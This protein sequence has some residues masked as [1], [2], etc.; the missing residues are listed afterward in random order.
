MPNRIRIMDQVE[1]VVQAQIKL[2]RQKL[3]LQVILAIILG[4]TLGLLF[5]PEADL[6]SPKV[7]E[8]LIGFLAPIGNIFLS[9][10]QLILVPLVFSSIIS[11]VAALK[12]P[13]KLR[14]VGIYTILCYLALTVLAIALGVFLMELVQPTSFLSPEQRE[15][16]VQKVKADQDFAGLVK[17][18][19]VE[20]SGGFVSSILPTNLFSTLASANMMQII[21]LAIIIGFALLVQRRDKSQPVLDLSDSMM[22]TSLTVVSFAMKIVP[23]AVFALT[24]DSMVTM[25]M[26]LLKILAI[27]SLVVIGGLV[28]TFILHMLV[29]R[30][31]A[32]VK[33]GY[34]LRSV[35]DALLL[36]FSTSSSA[37]TL[38]LTM[39]A[40]ME[41]FKVP[42]S[43]VR[44]VVPIGATIDMAGTALYQGS[45]AI[46]LTN[47]FGVHLDLP[48][49][50]GLMG[51]LTMVS[52]GAAA[53][54][55]SGLILLAGVLIGYGLPAGAVVVL[56]GVDRAL[57]MART[58]LNV[59]GDMVTSI[60]VG[61]WVGRR[62]EREA[63][64][65][66]DEVKE[67]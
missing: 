50:I 62:E 40:C 19:D 38:P 56:F 5:G 30:I 21:T 64:G 34:Y 15:T 60:L 1:K 2:V 3:H 25:G 63:G 53:V 32:G 20:G 36:A 42:E 23:F 47:L 35:K 37:A 44:F 43:I 49:K 66:K 8:R 9:I 28:L 57:D 22:N 27:F 45:A 17:T 29:L 65:A 7:T 10:I 59:N 13:Q 24:F 55:A 67:K 4:F 58:T 18:G 39:R 51:N 11:G 6:V 41:R 31:L 14:T 26:D 12:D 48:Q 61:K 16:L 54:P 46:F 52:I 33:V